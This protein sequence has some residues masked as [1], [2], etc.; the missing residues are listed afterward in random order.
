MILEQEILSA[1]AS[2]NST[3]RAEAFLKALLTRVFIM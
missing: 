1:F 2:V 3:K